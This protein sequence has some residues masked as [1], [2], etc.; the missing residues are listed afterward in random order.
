VARSARILGVETDYPAGAMEIGRRSRGTP[1]IANRLLRRVRDFAQ[2][3]AD[4]R[5]S[6]EV[7]GQA[8]DMLKVD[9]RGFDEQD[10]QLLW[11]MIDKFGGGPVGLDTLA[12]A[13]GEERGTIED[14][15]EPYLIQQ[16]FL[17][18]TPR[19]RVTTAH[20]YRHFG[21]AVAAPVVSTDLFGA[22]SGAP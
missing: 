2:I 9:E 13:M 7:A 15:L 17:M 1:R 3:R 19:G 12:A 8:L 21:L 16:G 11:L 20:A 4:G 14:V 10:R 5:I 6:V 18:R 22:G